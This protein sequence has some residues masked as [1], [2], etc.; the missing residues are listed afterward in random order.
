MVI[1][2]CV[3]VTAFIA[4][5]SCGLREREKQVEQRNTEL[6][7]KEQN[8]TLQEQKLRLK[9]D[10]LSKREKTLDSLE[11]IQVTE[12]ET[13]KDPGLEG[14]WTVRMRCIETNCAGSAVGDTRNEQWVFSYENNHIIV[15]AF[16]ANKLV[17]V[18]SGDYSSDPLLL[19]AQLDADAQATRMTVR[20]NR[21][22]P[23][24]MKGEREIIRAEGCT[25]LYALELKKQ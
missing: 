15:K 10:E 25:I 2:F 24:E 1:N 22:R 17:R 11:V 21:N 7:E 3:L 20:L 12:K 14:T 8:L 6:N 19:Y 23:N 9:E 4:I 16:S 5:S 13:L 18:Y